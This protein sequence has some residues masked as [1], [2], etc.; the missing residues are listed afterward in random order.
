[1][2]HFD[3]LPAGSYRLTTGTPAEVCIQS[4]TLSD[5]EVRGAPL[6]VAAGT[7]LHLDLTVSKSCGAVQ[8]RA[9]RDGVSVV[10]AKMVLLLNGTPKEPGQLMEDFANDEGELSFSGLTP[11]RYLLWAWAVDGKGA[12]TG[13]A[14]LVA[15]EQQATTVDVK[16]GQPVHID[17]PILKEEAPAQ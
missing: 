1:L 16:E 10:G 11:G 13:P 3:G 17:V 8:A 7:T 15:V 12:I 5:R 9:V 4:V 6:V 14:S 2:C